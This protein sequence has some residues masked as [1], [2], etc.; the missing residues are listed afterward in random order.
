MNR[1]DPQK[2][3]LVEW[4]VAARPIAG[5]AVSGDL[6]LVKPFDHG[7]LLAAV[8]GVG[9]GDE[10]TSAAR[11]AVGILEGHGRAAGAGASF[12]SGLIMAHARSGCSQCAGW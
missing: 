10:A 6:H 9:H 7:V 1:V 8:D 3:G 2:S 12:G 11:A 4:G 5:E